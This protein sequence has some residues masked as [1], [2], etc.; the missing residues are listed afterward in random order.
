MIYPDANAMNAKLNGLLKSL[1][2]IYRLLIEPRSA[3][4][5]DRRREYILNIILVGSIAMLLVLDAVVLYYAISWGSHDH[6]ISF[7]AF[8]MIPAFFV[9]LLVLSRRGHFMS[10][11]YL[12]IAAYFLSESY[13]VLRWTAD[14][15]PVLLGCALTIMF[16]SILIDTR[17]GFITTGVVGAFLILAHYLQLGAVITSDASWK[18]NAS[19]SDA[20]V[21]A[22]LL[23]LIMTVAWL[24]NREIEKSLTRARKSERELQHERDFL[25]V[26]VEERTEELRRAQFEKIEQVNQFAKFGQLASGLFH[27]VLNIMN[28]LSVKADFQAENGLSDLTGNG[29][30]SGNASVMTRQIEQFMRAIRKQLD[31]QECDEPFSLGEGIEQ[32]IQL[33]SYKAHCEG[34]RV[35]FVRE[36]K[37]DVVHFGN[38]FKFHQ[39]MFNLILNGIEAHETVPREPG[40]ERSVTVHVEEKNGSVIVAVNDKGCGIDESVR[41]NIFDQFFSTKTGSNGMGIGL[42][43][44]KKIVEED[45]RGTITVASKKGDGSVFIVEFPINKV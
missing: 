9:Y 12:L 23:F 41:E 43:S 38:S 37:F 25:E 42:A 10:A 14:M 15:P 40:R 34:V 17:F 4:E 16:A 7:W 33:L 5:D 22:A 39:V 8:S 6:G 11:S 31:R 44:V 2:L 32:V 18:Q 45:F 36:G 27:D 19:P 26:K 21:F 1:R 3:G 28:T 24:S 30:S 35:T 29:F 13:A 20:L